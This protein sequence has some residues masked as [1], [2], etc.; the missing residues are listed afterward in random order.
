ML[1][2]VV[3]YILGLKGRLKGGTFLVSYLKFV[4]SVEEVP[5]IGRSIVRSSSVGVCSDL[6]TLNF[7]KMT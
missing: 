3:Y 2:H 5:L 1:I 7:Q 4:Q 6:R